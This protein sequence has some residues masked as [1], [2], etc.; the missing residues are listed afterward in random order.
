VI[1]DSH[2]FPPIDTTNCPDTAATYPNCVTD[3]Q[4]QTEIARL[5]K[6]SGLPTG[7]GANAPIYFV[8]TPGNTNVCADS[9]DCT[10]NVF[11]AYHSSFTDGSANVLY[12]PDPLFF[13]GAS[14]AQDPKACQFDNNTAVQEPN[15]DPADVALKY[16]SH[17]FNETIT[18]PFPATGWISAAGQEDGDE[19]NF[20]NSTSDP[21]NDGNPDAF[22][23]TLGGSA[24]AG[25]LYDQAINGHHYY[26]QS[27]WSNQGLNC[28]MNPTPSAL[29]AA[30]T[31]PSTAKPGTAASFKPT[32]SSAAAGYSSTTWSWGDG[33]A[34]SFKRA[35]PATIS[36]TFAAR[37]L[38]T[39][40]LTLVDKYGNLQTSSH[41]VQVGTSPTAAFTFSPPSPLVGTP[42]SFDGSTSTDPGGTI[43]GYSWDFGDGSTGTGKTTSHAYSTAGTYTVKLTV[44][45]GSLTNSTTHMI[46]VAVTHGAPVSSFSAST[47]SAPAG[48]T[49]A[50]NGSGSGE[51]GGS[52]SSYSWSF[53]DGSSGT[54]ATASHAYTTAG[55]YTV[56]LTVTDASGA[57]AG[58]SQQIQITG[59]PKAGIAV[60]AGHA[61]AGV[62]FAFDGSQ[63]RDSGSTLTGYSWSFGDGGTATGVGPSHTFKKTGTFSVTLVVTDASGSTASVTESLVVKAPSITKVSVTK[64]SKSEKLKVTLSGP[65][66]LKLGS[67][68]SKVGR[69][70]TVTF[71]VKLSK[72]Q[73]KTLKSEHKL[74][75]HYK[76]SFSPAVGKKSSK[77]VTI[78]LKSK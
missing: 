32:G 4:I 28:R 44:S 70:R 7:S 19:C 9:T 57:T 67:T 8:V 49:V 56:A 45:D 47:L 65:G 77:T 21:N 75:V 76:L 3:A 69:P 53:G 1:N 51:A 46:T 64:G 11:C 6:A 27:E 26:T 12:S 30:F 66:T 52:I 37:G 13:N 74:T 17:E 23:P 59:V 58:S 22:L 62:P 24:S 54:G 18:D 2:V 50:F 72:K 43:S 68:K 42:V 34:S 16:T 25:T 48:A 38:Y 36:H 20:Y 40:T 31:P 29:T 14:S 15:G 55:T 73:L 78:K 71:K 63:S 41:Q 35:A 61:V 33:T 5:I 10:D 60:I 39:V